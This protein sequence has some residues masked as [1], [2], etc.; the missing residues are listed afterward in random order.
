[1]SGVPH[2]TTGFTTD[3]PANL[4]VPL[5]LTYAPRMRSACLFAATLVAY[6]LLG[7][8]AEAQGQ[9]KPAPGPAPAQTPARSSAQFTLRHD[10]AGGPEGV[11]ARSRARAGDCAGALA[12]FDAAIK[13]SV[14]ATLRRDRGLCHEKLGH[15][16][17]AIEDYRAYLTA[18]PDAADADQIRQR[19]ALLEEQAGVGG[20][21]SQSVKSN[22]SGV[23]ASAS[24]SMSIA[25]GR[26]STSSR[27]SSAMGPNQGEAERSYD[28]YAQQ[29]KLA[30]AAESSPL[31]HGTGVVLG[32]FLH[33]P[34]F[35]VGEGASSRLAYGVGAT[36]RYSTGPT[37][38]I[39]SELGFAGIGTSGANTSQ[40]GPLLMAGVELRLPITK[41]ASDNILL[42]GGV[43][44]ERYVVTGSRSINDN[45]LGRFAVGY[46]HVF[47]PS[48]GI[49]F[50]IDGGPAYVIPESADNRLNAVIGGSVAF[51]VGF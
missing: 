10:E 51:V 24:A 30:D 46:R 4:S 34:R 6:A 1:M 8:A 38:S 20:P 44:Y 22:E 43:G 2:F 50:L 14:E 23:G 5:A 25:S 15:P 9:P 12:G 48:I 7:S 26:A 21:S 13:N 33:M 3:S 47:G 28:Y 36:L 29:E 39:I 35:F 31:R 32:P 49:E 37:V 41:Y 11:E 45:L 40:S 16:F 42:R 17:P 18:S 19:L 27:R